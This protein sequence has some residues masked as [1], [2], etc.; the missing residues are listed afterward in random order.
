MKRK[1]GSLKQKPV[2]TFRGARGGKIVGCMICRADVEIDRGAL[3]GVCSTCIARVMPGPVPPKPSNAPPKLTK[4]GKPRAKRGTA[5]KKLPS[6]FPRGWHFKLLYKHTDGKFYSRG[7]LIDTVKA[8]KL[9][10]E[11]A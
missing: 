1:G 2:Q 11:L 7:K 4:A 5:V 9:A 6:G 8:K 10:K 3:A